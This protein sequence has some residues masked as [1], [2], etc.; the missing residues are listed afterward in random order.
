[1]NYRYGNS[2]ETYPITSG[3]IWRDES[4]GSTLAVG[5]LTAGLPEFMSGV[6]MLYCDPP[7]NLGNLNSFY[8]KA[9]RSDYRDM[10]SDFYK[11]FFL[12]I[13][14]LKPSVCYLEIGKQN[15]EVF[16]D[17]LSAIYPVIQEWPVTYYRKY[18][19]YLLRG[20]Q[21]TQ[22]FDFTGMDEGI[23]PERAIAAERGIRTVADLC[24]GQG[25]TAL[26]AFRQG[27]RF[28]GI[29]LNPRRLAVTIDR[30]NRIGGQYVRAISAGHR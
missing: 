28:F 2:W 29:E 14:L 15:R 20:G 9:G 5:D 16:R 18:S 22:P 11:E 7:W 25:L 3:E 12:Q 19:C 6:D 23:T 21:N 13:S 10:F 4:T 24:T 1:M 30:V 17:K 27:K 26:A 8:T